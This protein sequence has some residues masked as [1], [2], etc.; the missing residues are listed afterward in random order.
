MESL[1]ILNLGDDLAVGIMIREQCS[2]VFNV[3][4]LSCERGANEIDVMLNGEL[5]DVLFV[6]FT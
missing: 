5:G 6:F 1:M 2:N 3:G 4:G